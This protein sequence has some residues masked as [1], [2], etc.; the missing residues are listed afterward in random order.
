M[1]VPGLKNFGIFGILASGVGLMLA[2]SRGQKIFLKPLAGGVK[3]LQGLIN[4]MSDILSYSRLMALGLATAVIA[5]IVNQIAL[6]FGDMIPYVGWVV[7]VLILIGGH[8]FNLGIN[9]LSGFIHSGR[10]QFV[11]FFP[12]FLEGGGKRLQPTKSEL[13]YIKVG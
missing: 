10:L 2:E 9:A 11:E 3:I 4:V 7:A 6:L 1:K 8:I 5:L 13:K 12:K